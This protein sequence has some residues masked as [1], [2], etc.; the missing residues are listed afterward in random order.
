LD[1]GHCDIHFAFL[2]NTIGRHQNKKLCLKLS[3][4]SQRPYLRKVHKYL[5]N[6]PSVDKL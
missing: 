5:Q 3:S 1:L 6:M 2:A 4:N